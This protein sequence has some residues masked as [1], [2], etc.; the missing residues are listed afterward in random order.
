[1]SKQKNTSDFD[2]DFTWTVDG[3]H[4]DRKSFEDMGSLRDFASDLVSANEGNPKLKFYGRRYEVMDTCD[5]LDYGIC[6]ARVRL[7]RSAQVA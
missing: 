3:E 2:Y 7:A 5:M 1:M 4:W 6:P